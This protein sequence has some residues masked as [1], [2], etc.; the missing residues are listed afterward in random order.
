MFSLPSP[1][2]LLG[3]THSESREDSLHILLDWVLSGH[4]SRGRGQLTYDLIPNHRGPNN[5]FHKVFVLVRSYNLC[6]VPDAQRT[7]MYLRDKSPSSARITNFSV[8]P[9]ECEYPYS[10]WKDY[11]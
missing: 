9:R 4:R 6:R 10:E 2:L 3:A 11:M 1:S 8:L 7:Y 5:P